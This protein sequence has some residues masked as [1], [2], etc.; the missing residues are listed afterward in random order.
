MFSGIVVQGEAIGRTLGFPTANID[1]PVAKTKLRDGVY[2]STV[3]LAGKQ[4]VGA[5][6]IKA[7]DERVEVFLLN[8]EG[9]EF[10]GSDIRVEP[11]AIVSE[12]EM[13]HTQQELKEKITNDV[14]LV[15][16][17]CRD[18]GIDI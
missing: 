13:Y 16:L 3:T 14:H 8:Y 17:T 1:I 10:Y 5:L 7:S 18:Y 11:I 12:Y 9:D 6:A 2:A 15:R 4:Y